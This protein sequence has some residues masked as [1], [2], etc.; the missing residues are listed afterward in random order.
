MNYRRGFIRLWVVLSLAWIAV[1]WSTQDWWRIELSCMYRYGPW[2]D[3]GAVKDWRD[4]LEYLWGP[5]AF[6]LIFGAALGWIV[7]GFRRRDPRP[8]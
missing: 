3:Y 2:C 7:T 8:D 5:P 4:G 1:I 6:V